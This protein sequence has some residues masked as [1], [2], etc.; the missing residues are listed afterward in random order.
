MD[1]ARSSCERGREISRRTQARTEGEET[2]VA[3]GGWKLQAAW[4]EEGNKERRDGTGADAWVAW[5][6][7]D[8]KRS[9]D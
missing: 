1:S 7:D 2:R 3:R 4:A 8:L 6:P 9:C 5:A